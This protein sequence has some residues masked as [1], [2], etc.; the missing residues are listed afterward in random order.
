MM[1]SK[2]KSRRGTI[3]IKERMVYTNRT[4]TDLFDSSQ[5]SSNEEIRVKKD[6]IK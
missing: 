4:L 1:D 3:W 6:E 5:N 2:G